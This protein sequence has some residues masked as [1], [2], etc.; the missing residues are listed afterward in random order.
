MC[1]LAELPDGEAR[2]VVF[3]DGPDLLRLFV[4]RRAEAVW[5]Y[6]NVCPHNYVPL[7]DQPDRFVSFDHEWIVCSAHGAVFRYEDGYCEDGPCKGRCLESVAVH[8]EAGTVVVR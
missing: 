1:R 5:G 2:E 4:V 8:V 3:G 7:N 6:V